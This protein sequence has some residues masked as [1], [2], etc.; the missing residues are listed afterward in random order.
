MACLEADVRT[1]ED[2]GPLPVGPRVLEDAEVGRQHVV[3]ARVVQ[4]GH[5]LV[6]HQHR[7]T[8]QQRTDRWQRDVVM[9]DRHLSPRTS[10][11]RK[12]PRPRDK[13]CPVS[14]F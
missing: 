9:L 6:A 1:G 11:S 13:V 7:R 8:P 10:Y 2:A 4:A 5:H 3:E 12:T 14:A